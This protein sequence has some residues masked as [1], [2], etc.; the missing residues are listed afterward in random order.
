MSGHVFPWSRV[1][2]SARQNG[3]AESSEAFPP[4]QPFVRSVLRLSSVRAS[5]AYPYQIIIIRLTF[6]TSAPVR[7]RR[8]LPAAAKP[9]NNCMCDGFRMTLSVMRAFMSIRHRTKRCAGHTSCVLCQY[10]LRRIGLWRRPLRTAPAQ[11][12]S[13]QFN[14]QCALHRIDCDAVSVPK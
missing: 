8:T 9:D 6:L 12:R 2:R 11:F 4:V 10:A 5:M 7:S 13:A 1:K 3:V 14:F